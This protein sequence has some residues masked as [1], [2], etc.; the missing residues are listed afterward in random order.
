MK[1]IKKFESVYDPKYITEISDSEY[2]ELT[3]KSEPLTTSEK[4]EIVKKLTEWDLNLS[5]DTWKSGLFYIKYY[6]NIKVVIRKIEDEYYIVRFMSE[7]KK[8]K[9]DQFDSL[10]QCLDSFFN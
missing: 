5:T 8:Y 9:C 3:N 7:D 1:Y 4:S 10:I 2:D 6:N